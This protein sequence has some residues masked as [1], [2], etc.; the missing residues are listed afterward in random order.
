[1]FAKLANHQKRRVYRGF[2]RVDRECEGQCDTEFSS[3]MS[4]NEHHSIELPSPADRRPGGFVE[5]A[6]QAAIRLGLTRRSA[7]IFH[8]SLIVRIISTV[9][10]RRRLRT[11]DARDRDQRLHSRPDQRRLSAAFEINFIVGLP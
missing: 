10:A 9:K 4:V 2:C 11:S 7:G 3:A 5:Y 1:L 6:D 8:A